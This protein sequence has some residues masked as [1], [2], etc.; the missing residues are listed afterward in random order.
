MLAM[1][2]ERPGSIPLI[3]LHRLPSL[4]ADVLDWM[5][6]FAGFA[7]SNFVVRLP[8]AFFNERGLTSDVL[9]LLEEYGLLRTNRDLSKIFRSQVKDR[10]S[11]NLLY[12]DKVIRVTHAD[13]SKE[14]TLQSYRLTEFGAT[15]ARIFMEE[16]ELTSDTEY[17]IEIVKLAQK[18]GFMVAQADILARAS[19]QIVAKHSPFCDIV[20][21]TQSPLR[22][23][24]R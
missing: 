10:F 20:A 18:Q 19:D 6:L 23:A 15:L 11:T 9:L 7:I 1:E 22:S 4:S 14:F 24:T 2:V 12:I 8:D 17:V 21:L 5:R 16:G 3:A 13:A